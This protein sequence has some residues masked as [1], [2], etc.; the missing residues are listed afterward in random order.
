MPIGPT[1]EDANSLSEED[2]CVFDETDNTPLSPP[3]P[4]VAPA[5][6]PSP[7][8]SPSNIHPA[9]SPQA[10]P[11]QPPVDQESYLLVKPQELQK[12]LQ[13][14]PLLELPDES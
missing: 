2:E 8:L 4:S 3:T 10:Q 13:E 14:F 1:A 11:P 9:P 5:P 6:S 12:M 7:P